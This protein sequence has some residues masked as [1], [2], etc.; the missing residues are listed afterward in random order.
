M[1]YRAVHSPLGKV[2]VFWSGR[3]AEVRVERVFLPRPD[4]ADVLRRWPE[5]VERGNPKVDALCEQV[6]RYLRGEMVSLSTDLLALDRYTPFSRQVM[7]AV[8]AIP[9]GQ[10]RAYGQIAAAV[11]RPRAARAVGNVM[12][13]NP[14]PLVIPC[15]RVIRADGTVGGFGGNVALKLKLLELEG[16]HLAKRGF[17][18]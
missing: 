3:G 18:I 7:L 12:A 14:F 4:I 8:H 9:R 2:L 17:E 15:H 1:N 16:V 5:A 11:G 10:V 6:A 13:R